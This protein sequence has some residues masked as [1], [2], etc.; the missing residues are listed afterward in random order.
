MGNK[1]SK[2]TRREILERTFADGN[3]PVPGFLE[4]DFVAHDGDS[5]QGTYLRA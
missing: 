2:Q 4:V 1:I 5:V 3:E